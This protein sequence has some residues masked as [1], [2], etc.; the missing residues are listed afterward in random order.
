MDIQEEFDFAARLIHRTAIRIIE[1]SRLTGA[2]KGDI[3]QDLWLELLTRLPKY[4]VHRG[5][6]RAFI[7]LVLKNHAASILKAMT[8]A[9]RARGVPIRSLNKVI[10][11][12]SDDP[13]ELHETIS[14]DDYLRLTR[15]PVRTEEERLDLALDVREFIAKLPPS[16]RVVCLLLIERDVTDIAGVIGIPRST[17]RDLISRLRSTTEGLGMDDHRR[18]ARRVRPKS[19]R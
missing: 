9:K 6:P 19:D 14:V 12:D 15:G 1:K 16:D 11:D 5:H 18:C 4:Q 17:L 3:Q 8:A 10:S 2:D 7:T 13:Q